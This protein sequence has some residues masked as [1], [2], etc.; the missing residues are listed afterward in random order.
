VLTRSR[1]ATAGLLMCAAVFATSSCS[2]Q[3][4]TG[5]R[6]S[7]SNGP[8]TTDYPVVVDTVHLRLPVQEYTATD[9]QLQTIDAAR[10]KLV[11]NCLQRFGIKMAHAPAP[12]NTNADG[13]RSLTD[14]RYGVYDLA[15]A[16]KYGYGMGQPHDPKPQPRSD[17]ASLSPEGQTVLTGEGRSRIKGQNVPIG[18]CQA[19]SDQA[20]DARK[21]A[22]T[23]DSLIQNLSFGSFEWSQHDPRVLA[24]FKAWSKCMAGRQYDYRDPLAPPG[25]P[26]LTTSPASKLEIATA[27]TDIGCKKQTNLVGVWFTVESDYQKHQINAQADAFKAAKEALNARVAIAQKTVS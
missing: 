14:R 2:P 23:D 20:L 6:P 16:A 27:T 12:T 9:T 22:G 10:V 26:Q 17:E 13:P 3:T 1:A 8:A 18:G 7:K 19:E 15:L 5:P 25:D 24:V 21:P 4:A 11:S